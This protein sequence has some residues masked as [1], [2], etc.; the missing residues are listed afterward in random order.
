M[1]GDFSSSA[2]V[3]GKGCKGLITTERIFGTSKEENQF[4]VS[5]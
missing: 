5:S 1:V 4:L 3:E 2:E